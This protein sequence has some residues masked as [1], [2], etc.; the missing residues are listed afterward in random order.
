MTTQASDPKTTDFLREAFATE[1]ECLVSK[2]K[3]S[4]RITHAGDRGEVNEQHFID[5]L[6]KYLPNRYTVEKAIIIDSYGAVSDSIDVV[7]FDRQYTPALL[8]NDK[9]RYVPAEAVYAVFECKPTINKQLLEYAADKAASVRKLHRTSVEI[10]TANGVWRAKK[11]FDIIAGILA[12]DVDWADGFGKS[13]HEVHATLTGDR[14]LDCGFAAAG[15][16]FDLFDG[17]GKYRFGPNEN[18][19]AY[20]AFRLLHG[21]QPRAT[22]PAVDW[23]AYANRLSTK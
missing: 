8:D 3:S 10:H 17:P 23:M 4:R 14:A 18:A 11:H 22:V 9:H 2:L 7:V 20:F 13:F 6:R 1:Q 21:L 16:S 5:F 19:L 12:I 15:A